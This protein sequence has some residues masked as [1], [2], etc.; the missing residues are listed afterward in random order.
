MTVHVLPSRPTAAVL[1]VETIP[2]DD[3][4]P[5]IPLLDPA[6]PLLWMSG[7][8]GIAGRGEAIRL[9]FHGEHRIADA[10]RA[11]Q[12]LTAHTR[13]DDAVHLPGTGLV[14]FGAF[15]FAPTSR[16]P[17]VLIVPSLVVG[18]RGGQRWL[19]RLRACPPE[20]GAEPGTAGAQGTAPGVPP[21][22]GAARLGELLGRARQALLNGGAAGIQGPGQARHGTV[23]RL[24]QPAPAGAEYRITFTPG[25][26]SADRYRAAVAAGVARIGR[27]DLTK[28]VLARDV[29]GH[30]PIGADLRLA[31][32]TLST[33]YPQCWTYA[34]DGLLGS[35][36]E[37]LITVRDGAFS[38]RVLAGTTSRGGDAAADHTHS[39]DLQT[40]GKDHREHELAVQ[41]VVSTLQAHSNDLSR[42]PEPYALKLPNLW[43]LAT[44]VHGTLADGSTSLDLVAALHPTAAVAGT[45]AAAASE[46][47]DELEPFDRGRYAGPVGWLGADGDG[48]WAIALRGAQIDEERTI[49]AYAGCGIVAGSDPESELKESAMKLRPIVETFG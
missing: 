48:E 20:Q 18:R 11:W 17:S 33:S 15:T 8:E 35:S 25:A 44:D 9:E 30:L 46:A 10:A 31:L 42:S 26:M 13:V 38:A 28:V 34:V 16:V 49:T 12:E 21:H 24:P 4:D 5:L 19:T 14:A 41:S 43:H 47:I 32:H 39:R 27:G 6:R 45:P 2:L 40:N 37:T 7:A 22:G 23:P 1:Q 29:V 3:D 36:P